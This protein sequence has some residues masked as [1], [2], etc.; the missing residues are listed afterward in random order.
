MGTCKLE[1]GGIP[2]PPQE[3]Q[4]LAPPVS[5]GKDDVLP[6]ARGE[7]ARGGEDRAGA[8]RSRCRAPSEGEHR[9]EGARP[10]R[11]RPR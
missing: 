7:E 8:P 1:S 11:H 6:G 2:E 3:A 10:R 9:G 5:R 4:E